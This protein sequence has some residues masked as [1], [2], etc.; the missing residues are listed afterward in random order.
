M[1]F[2]A[3]AAIEAQAAALW[4]LYKLEI[5]F[6]VEALLDSLDLGYYWDPMGEDV[7]AEI[8]PEQRR[9]R[10]NQHRLAE[11]ESNRGLYRFTI[12]HEIGHWFLHAEPARAGN[13]KLFESEAIYCR[14]S[15]NDP[16]ETQA[17][18]F[19]GALLAPRDLLLS[20]LP[21]GP[22][23]GWAPVYG[24]AK[25]FGMSATAVIVRLQECGFAHRDSNGLPG[26]GAPAIPGQAT[27]FEG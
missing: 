13:L 8:R 21:Q 1:T 12:A 22:W 5:S 17:H 6:D 25:V 20:R 23:V 9:I 24:L 10:F 2:I 18:K 26:S 4:R 19:A 27:L 7:L 11:F 15:T 16:V 3:A 14:D